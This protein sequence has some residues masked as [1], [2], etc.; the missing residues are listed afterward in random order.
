MI[1]ES[2]IRQASPADFALVIATDD[3][4]AEPDR[5]RYVRRAIERRDCWVAVSDGRALGY[6]I[7]DESFFGH[8]FVWLLVV[9]RPFRRRGVATSLMRH[10]QALF[11]G[12]KLFT[13]TNESNL[14]SQR[15]LESLGFERSGW[16]KNLDED[17]PEIVYVK[18]PP[19]AR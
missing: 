7:V 5:Q 16:L 3:L 14:P 18:R 9:A 8:P 19:S 1:A 2:R 6:L 15:L 11:E 17:D 13:S 10:A 12:R 4:G